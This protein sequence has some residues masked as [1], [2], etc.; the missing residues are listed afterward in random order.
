MDGLVSSTDRRLKLRRPD[1][2]AVC[3]HCLSAGETAIWDTARRHVRCV[4]C[5]P[6]SP[7]PAAPVQMSAA[8]ASARREYERRRSNRE[9]RVRGRLGNTLGGMILAVTDEPQHQRAWARGADGEIKL[10]RKLERWTAEHGVILLHDRRMPL[11]KGNIDHIA[12]G[13]SGVTV[14]D[15]KRYR[16]RIAVER[17]GGLVAPQTEHLLVRGRDQTKLVDGVL[18]QADAVH[19]LL[20]D[21]GLGPVPI[22]AVLCFVDGDWPLLGRLEVRGVPVLPPRHA[23]K[24]C[25]AAGPLDTAVIR[26]IA[27]ALAERLPPA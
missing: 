7:P 4:G 2:C 8:G 11:G 17:R 16:G 27:N 5:E 1:T 3:A 10:A 15:A 19:Q 20:A 24:L 9:A 22:A 6:T 26:E 23:A 13:T 18:A 25:R 12:V 14:L 21:G